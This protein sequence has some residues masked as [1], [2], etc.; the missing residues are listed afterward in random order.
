[1][2]TNR[3]AAATLLG[4]TLWTASPASA[5][6]FE[7][8]LAGSGQWNA[9][10]NW[11][12]TDG[13]SRSYPNASG[14]VAKFIRNLGADYTAT[15]PSGAT[16]T[17]GKFVFQPKPYYYSKLTV[18]SGYNNTTA[19]LVLQ[20][21]SGTA[22]IEFLGRTS[23]VKFG[24]RYNAG[25]LTLD[26]KS[27]LLFTHALTGSNSV[28]VGFASD[29]QANTARF[30]TSAGK[31]DV[32]IRPTGTAALT[33]RS[34]SSLNTNLS[35]WYV[36]GAASKL[37]IKS[38]EGLGHA[39]SDVVLQNGGTLGLSGSSFAL[40]HAVKGNGTLSA[41]A[42]TLDAGGVLAPGESVGALAI[43]AASLTLATG[44]ELKIELASATSNDLI[45]TSCDVTL[46]GTLTLLP[47]YSPSASTT[48]T[49]LATAADKVITGS[50]GNAL[51]EGYSYAVVSNGA[52][53]GQDLQVTY[54]PEPATLALL[55]VGGVGVLIRR[56][57]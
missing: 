40:T 36:D 45:T 13:T 24:N 57:R 56:R 50:F 15:V 30:T 27:D 23:E 7:W 39:D 12:R 11:V 37:E 32:I 42:L 43:N 49:I 16:Y 41:S 29:L 38:N 44:S 14:D 48:W 33:V 9:S 54:I 53:G 46:G 34:Y 28:L 52:T 47:G 6:T 51:P 2:R 35:T 31:Q 5:D 3:I 1:M 26:L 19:K 18:E 4:L 8:N 20:D 25:L 22:T 10:A 17:V 21:P 55:A